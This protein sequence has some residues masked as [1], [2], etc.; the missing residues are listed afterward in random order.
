MLGGGRGFV[1]EGVK[2]VGAVEAA[3][4]ETETGIWGVSSLD[5]FVCDSAPSNEPAS[6]SSGVEG[7][8]ASVAATTSVLLN[9]SAVLKLGF[10]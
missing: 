9:K 5:S 8:P 2:D 7:S 6:G 1:P 4:V 10:A 3:G